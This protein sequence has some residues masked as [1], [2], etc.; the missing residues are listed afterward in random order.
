MQL[1]R[2]SP[3]KVR[4]G[5]PGMHPDGGGLYL[6]VTQGAGGAISRTWLFRFVS[7][8]VRK[9]RQMGLGALR[10]VPLA[11]ARK[12]AAEARALKEHGIDPIEERESARRSAAAAN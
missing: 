6:Q 8:E 10:D 9:E 11:E 7:P 12:K 5:G 3:A 1:N 4:A 2:L